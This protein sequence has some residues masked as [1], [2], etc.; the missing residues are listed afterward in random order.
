MTVLRAIE[1]EPIAEGLTELVEYLL[2]Q[3][4]TGRVSSVSYAV[5]YRDGSPD[6]AYSALPSR[7]AMI[8]AVEM[9]KYD[10]LGGDE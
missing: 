6:W 10:M 7:P 4:E 3:I 2:A 8:G 1:A 9:L 5:I